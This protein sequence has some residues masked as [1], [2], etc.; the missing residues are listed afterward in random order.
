MEQNKDNKKS[1]GKMLLPYLLF[2]LLGLCCLFRLSYLFLVSNWEELTVD[3]ILF[4]IFAPMGGANGHLVQLFITTALAPAILLWL[5]L[6][7]FY[8]FFYQ[9]QKKPIATKEEAI[10]PST[11]E[12][13]APP[14]EEIKEASKEKVA[15]SKLKKAIA[16]RLRSFLP[17]IKKAFLPLCGFFSI[18]LVAVTIAEAWDGISLGSFL[19]S[20]FQSSKFIEEHYA[21]P[22][23]VDLKFPEKKRNLI[24]IYMESTE[25]TFM[26]KEHGGDF[27]E[28]LL[29]E[30]TAL[31]EEG[32]DFAGEGE[33]RNGGIALP[34]ATWT[35]GAI[36]GESTGLPLK[37]SIEQNSMDSQ[38]HFFPSVTALGDILEEEGYNQKFL[39]GSVG[40][41]GGRELFM[42]DHGNVAVEDFSYWK[43]KGKFPRNYWVNWGFEDE[44]LF[45]YAKEELENLGKAEQPFN[46]TLLTVDT[47]FPDGYVCRLCERKH[48]KNQYADVYQCTSRQVSDFVHWIQQQPFY[49]NT[50]IV[51]SGDHPTMDHDFCNDVEKSY[52]RKVFTTYL[53]AVPGVEEKKYR[54][55]STFDDFPTTLAAM[56]VEIPGD[57]LGLGRNLFS[58]TPTLIEEY[59][60]K[61][62]KKELEKRS[63]FM[64]SLGQIDKESAF[65][66]KEEK[67]KEKEEKKKKEVEEQSKKI[68]ETQRK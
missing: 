12:N 5:S 36:F 24:Y 68:K 38:K 60:L 23:N 15:F 17:K 54:E 43:R 27:P 49:E 14:Y 51:I 48:P 30:L 26:D 28:N 57:K 65:V 7:V 64:I 8:Y 34:G 42:E 35:M 10:T 6:S 53:N 61:H 44:K 56:G 40:Y 58:K 50:T 31:G 47:H 37:I 22:K 20:Q 62:V 32:E 59:G 11:G 19:S 41:F 2:F 45:L 25:L 33:K 4:H 52:Q 63:D 66:Q 16:P 9:K 18:F 46:L 29:P 67:K 3:E 21:D 55:Y 39:L 1:I 13:I